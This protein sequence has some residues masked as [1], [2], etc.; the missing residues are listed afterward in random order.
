MKYLLLILLTFSL[1]FAYD[2]TPIYSGDHKIYD[3]SLCQTGLNQYALACE[4]GLLIYDGDTWTH[5]YSS[6]PVW[7][8]L[9]WIDQ[10]LILI[11]G[12]GSYS[13]GV[14]KFNEYTGEFEIIECIYYPNFLVHNENQQEYFIGVFDG[15]LKSADGE[16]WEEVAYFSG[17]HCYDMVFWE[18]HYVVSVIG[19]LYGVYYS[20]DYGSSWNFCS[21][22]VFL[23]TDMSFRNDSK[24][25]GV[26]PGPTDM[27]GLWSSTDFGVSW[28]IEYWD[29][30]LSSVCNDVEGNTFI[31]WETYDGV[32]KLENG[33]I[34]P[35]N[36]GLPCPYINK[37][38]VNPA[39]SSIHIMA[40]TNSGAYLLTN[41]TSSEPVL[42]TPGIAL[43]N[44]PNPFNPSTTI[45]FDLTSKKAKVEIYNSKGQKIDELSIHND[46][47]SI[48]WEANNF[49]SGVYLYKLIVGGKEIASNKML[50][51]K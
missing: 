14:Y 49:P 45:S 20:D 47:S 27:S 31:G 46:Q 1:L 36:N 29:M 43:Y 34:I 9:P 38:Y 42:P 6:L 13:D 10:Q 24:L 39:M 11:Q 37:L 8:V 19:N 32:A 48:I 25:F 22:G 33:E 18:N 5:H 2:W 23:V 30:F 7:N 28:E 16:V 44:F 35:M 41:Y 15:L 40:F 12:N 50:L 26:Y 17:R 3:F 51:L 21:N 4:D